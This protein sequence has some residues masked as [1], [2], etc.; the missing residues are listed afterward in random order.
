MGFARRTRASRPVS[1]ALMLALALLPA[2]AA[3]G[4]DG[5]PAPVLYAE[6]VGEAAIEPANRYSENSAIRIRLLY[7]A[8]HPRAGRPWR[9]YAGPVRLEEWNTDI[10]D[11]RHGASRLPAEVP[12]ADGERMVVLKSLARYRVYDLRNMPVPRVAVQFGGQLR[13][14]ELPQWMDVDG[15][16]KTD[17]LE[18]R[19]D[20]IVARA[21]ASTVAEVAEVF[22][23]L[24]GWRQSYRRDCGGFDESE[25]SVA[26]IS[27]VCLDWDG[28]NAHRLNANRELSA[29]VLHEAYHVWQ[30]RHPESSLAGR[31]LLKAAKGGRP[32][33]PCAQAGCVEHL[34]LPDPRYGAQEAAAEAFAE[35]YKHLFP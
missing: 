33:S 29:T 10:Y 13:F 32:A 9:G 25:P 26:G 28:V 19:V 11:G 3:R 8:G 30:H 17:W 27:A 5:A 15:N 20:D 22:A 18:R 14:V 31:R 6:R 23:V 2:Q 7:P 24:G 35:T 34:W 12:V 1:V 21:R 4:A 16:D